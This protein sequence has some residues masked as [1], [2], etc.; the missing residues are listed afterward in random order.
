MKKFLSLSIVSLF[1]L[2]ATCKKTNEDV[3]APGGGGPNV[4]LPTS[5]F[6]CTNGKTYIGNVVNFYFT[7]LAWNLTSYT[8]TPDHQGDEVSFVMNSNN[9]VSI[10]R[11][12]P[13]VS[14]GIT[15]QWFAIEENSYPSGSGFPNN[16]YLWDIQD[17]QS[18]LTQFVIKRKDG[19]NLKFTIE[20]K[21]YPGYYLGV[22]K[23]K[24]AVQDVDDNLTF[25]TSPKEWWFEKL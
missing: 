9:T 14:N 20:S 22:G 7:T 10:K 2:S 16:L 18:E 24:N 5:G 13:H 17:E 25:T 6:L 21:K 19:D 11:N 3:P 8:K 4:T 23:R 1:L 15:Y 12:K